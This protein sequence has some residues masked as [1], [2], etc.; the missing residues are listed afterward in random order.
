MP[1]CLMRTLSLVLGS[2]VVYL[3]V[4]CASG[5]PTDWASQTALDASAMFE[6]GSPE[7]STSAAMTESGAGPKESGGMGAVVDLIADAVTDPVNRAA[8]DPNMSGTRLKTQR[9]VGADG[10]SSFLGM[11]DSQLNVACSFQKAADGSTRC[12]PGYPGAGDA[13]YFADAACSQLVAFVYPGCVAPQY[14]FWSDTTTSCLT[15]RAVHIYS[16]AGAY[17][18]A[19]YAGT[20][21]NCVAEPGLATA[22]T[23][24]S[25]EN[26]IAPSQFVQA[27]VQTDP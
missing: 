7:S 1:H 24:Y 22:Y 8:A 27:T 13:L 12:L 10:S 21:S 15:T 14:A 11:Y 17:S 3:F 5:L 4:A 20:P 16:V 6:S 9:Y 26:E 2:I 19:V 18:G 23:F 25:L